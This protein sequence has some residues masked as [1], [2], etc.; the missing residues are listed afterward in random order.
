MT[1]INL[2]SLGQPHLAPFT[3]TVGGLKW[4]LNFNP[5][6]KDPFLSTMNLDPF[7]HLTRSGETQSSSSSSTVTTG[8]GKGPTL[9]F[10]TLKLPKASLSK[11]SSTGP[12]LVPALSKAKQDKKREGS[13]P[14]FGLE[15]KRS[16]TKKNELMKVNKELFGSDDEIED[17]D[18]SDDLDN[19][20]FAAEAISNS[21]YGSYRLYY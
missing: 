8:S 15:N 19:T 16:K 21:T 3:G 11:S 20:K 17:V 9:G 7:P 13:L 4:P 5:F 2:C 10:S 14:K 12:D 1:Q 18:D 6:L